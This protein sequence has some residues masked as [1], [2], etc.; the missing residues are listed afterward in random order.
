MGNLEERSLPSSVA[1]RLL[2]D[3]EYDRMVLAGRADLAGTARGAQFIEE[4]S[5]V[6]LE[7]LP[8]TWDIVL[9]IDRLDRTYRLTRTTIDT[10]IGLD[11]EHPLALIYAIDRT[12]LDT[13][14]VFDV[15]TWFCDDVCHEVL[16][17]S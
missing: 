10:L 9:V 16:I 11:V 4:F 2:L 15:D 1:L 13:G 12:L 6:A 5:V 8:L 17:P 3:L 7:S 14:L